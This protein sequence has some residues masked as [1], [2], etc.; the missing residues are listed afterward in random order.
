MAD[1]FSCE[2][3]GFVTFESEDAVE[4][5]CEEQFHLI[6]DKKVITWFKKEKER[7]FLYIYRTI[8]FNSSN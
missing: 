3:F 4:S 5:A 1:F 6:N 2:G 8:N 7:G